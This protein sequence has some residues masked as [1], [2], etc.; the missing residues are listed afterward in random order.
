M[1][2]VLNVIQSFSLGGAARTVFG[3]SKYSSAHGKY[4]HLMV[5]LSPS[6]DDSE[7]YRVAEENGIEILRPQTYGDLTR[8]VS[9]SD[10]VLLH[11]WNNPEL[12][13]FI[14]MPLPASRLAAWVHVGGHCDPQAVPDGLVSFLDFAIAGS[15]YTHE[16]AAFNQLSPCTRAAKTEMVYDATDFS[17]LSSVTRVSHVGFNVGYIGT[18]DFQKMHPH[19]VRM[20]AAAAIPD[21]KFIVCGPGSEQETILREA[22]ALGREGSFDVRGMVHDICPVLSTLD[23]YG[24]PLCE[25]NYAAAELNLQEVMYCGI[26]PVVF[27]YGGVKHLV[28]HDVTGYVVHTEREYAEALEHLYRC[29]ADRERLGA[30]AAA[31]ARKVFGAERAAEKFNLVLDRLMESEKQTRP[32]FSPQ[33]VAPEAMSEGARRFNDS[34]KSYR[35]LFAR[36]VASTGEKA[37]FG[38]DAEIMQLSALMKRGGIKNYRRFYATDPFLCFWSGLVGL[39]EGDLVGALND[40]IAALQNKFEHWRLWWYVAH[41]AHSLGNKELTVASIGHLEQLAPRFE[42]LD[43]L[44]RMAI[45]GGDAV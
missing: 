18:V 16:S 9:E 12:D 37:L 22:R 31:Y 42:G 26:P 32:V 5:S 14:R 2:R 17:R 35:D 25:D 39:S 8:A 21:V 45:G 23:V 1:I 7:A 41:V 6:M 11:W 24:Y 19:Y 30:N 4:H 34:L 13:H 44:R 40:F 33:S 3:T 15:P 10:I 38:A 20:S 43:A 28:T 36:S 27:P 29:P